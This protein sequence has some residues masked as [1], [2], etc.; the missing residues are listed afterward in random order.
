MFASNLLVVRRKA[1]LNINYEARSKENTN[2]HS[3]QS[4]LGVKRSRG[5]KYHLH[6]IY[7]LRGK[8][9][10]VKLLFTEVVCKWFFYNF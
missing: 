6:K 3:Y 7:L 5:I 8:L 2:F 4:T 10:R 1:T 9:R